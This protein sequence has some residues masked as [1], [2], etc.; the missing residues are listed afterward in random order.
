L[1][2]SIIRSINPPFRLED[3]G[4]LLLVGRLIDVAAVP[5]A[6]HEIE[7]FPLT[8]G[9]DPLEKLGVAVLAQLGDQLGRSTS[10]SAT[11]C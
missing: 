9:R 11:P 2:G 8:V 3:R 7:V 10:R 5:L 6:E 4:P 1:G